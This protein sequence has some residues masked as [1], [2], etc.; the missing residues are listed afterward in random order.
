MKYSLSQLVGQGSYGSVYAGVANEKRVAVKVM[1][2][3]SAKQLDFYTFEH[4]MLLY[5][6]NKCGDWTV[7][8][9]DAGLV[10]REVNDLLG[11]VQMQARQLAGCLV[12]P[13]YDYILEGHLE[14][15]RHKWKLFSRLG[16]SLFEG[17][18]VLHEA[19][20]AHGDV[21]PGN[22]A[23][24]GGSRVVFLD[25]SISCV[26]DTNAFT[27]VWTQVRDQLT[28]QLAETAAHT[29]D[30]TVHDAHACMDT[31]EEV[32]FHEPAPHE[33]YKYSLPPN[34]ERPDG[35]RGRRCD[36][37]YGACMV[38]LEMALGR[39]LDDTQFVTAA[40]RREQVMRATRRHEYREL[41]PLL[42]EALT[43]AVP[44]LDV[45]GLWHALAG[46]PAPAGPPPLT[47]AQ[48]LVHVP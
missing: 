17:L 12:M 30:P 34:V 42:L 46:K 39:L 28:D 13:Q 44:V 10:L 4:A 5:A 6:H 32:W 43:E 18:Q 22:I 7:P 33:C 15:L 19:G 9:L 36:D 31:L 37:Q 23:V 14:D 40:K 3:A 47:R 35:W 11:F 25:F 27:E 8:L 16:R 26:R 45:R 38:L 29:D 48:T 24:L 1:P 21:A 2:L 41:R 20:I